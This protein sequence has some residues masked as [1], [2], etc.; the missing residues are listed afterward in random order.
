M[1]NKIINIK[2]VRNDKVLV[3]QQLKNILGT[4]QDK[5]SVKVQLITRKS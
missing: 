2:Y 4:K 3:E 5:T 1:Y